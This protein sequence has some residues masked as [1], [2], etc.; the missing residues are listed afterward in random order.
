MIDF[1][2]TTYLDQAMVKFVKHIVEIM[3]EY[4]NE[5]DILT[6]LERSIKKMFKSDVIEIKQ[7]KAKKYGINWIFE[8]HKIMIWIIILLQ[9]MV[10]AMTFVSF[11]G[12]GAHHIIQNPEI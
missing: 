7:K 3:K 12:K 8:A 11:E 9:F 2:K 6:D 1:L 4:T 10:V 5:G